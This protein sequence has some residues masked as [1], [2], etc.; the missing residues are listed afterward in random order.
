VTGLPAC[1]K[2]YDVRG[3]VPDDLDEPLAERIGQAF[4]ALLQQDEP[5][6]TTRPRVAV[7][8]DVRLSS[9]RLSAALVHGLTRAGADVLDLGLV[10]T[11]MV[12]FAVFHLGLQGGIM[13]TASHNPAGYNGMKL[14]RA[15]ARPVSADSGLHQLGRAASSGRSLPSARRGGRAERHDVSAAYLDH[16]L[17]TIDPAALTGLHVVADAGNGCAG[18]VLEQL[19]ERL[20]CRLTVL[21][22]E[23]DG[24]FPTGVPNPLLPGNREH[25]SAAVRR[26]GAELGIAF[27]GDFD[28]CF[29]FD[30]R[31]RFIEGYYLV[32]LLAGQVL[33]R[34]PGGRILHDPRLYWNTVE[35]VRQ[36]GGQPILARTGHAF[37]KERMRTADAV[38]GGEM[39]AHHYFRSFRYCDSGMIPWLV[40]AEILGRTGQS[41]SSLVAD[42]MSR[43]PCSGEI[44]RRVADQP[45]VV[46]RVLGRYQEAARSVDHT[47]GISLEFAEWRFNLRSSNTEPLLRLN[48]ETRGDAALLRVKTAELL[49]LVDGPPTDGGGTA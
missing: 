26:H 47:D 3:R 21:R 44:N 27:D 12:Y 48:V 42:R 31:G 29:F 1:F 30:E 18:P 4:V 37:I 33:S 46:Q 22:G 5:A 32:G 16:A 15:D 6:S 45:A 35:V 28:R 23:P 49:A 10:G 38:Y 11:E 17:A 24:S 14:V 13:V 8:R 19:A 41:L 43:F 9:P 36:A 40:V 34:T 2:A 7:G 20:P 39:S 25:C